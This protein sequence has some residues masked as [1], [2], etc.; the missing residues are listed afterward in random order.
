MA[1]ASACLPGDSSPARSDPDA[2]RRSRSGAVTLTRHDMQRETVCDEA[3]TVGWQ[4][5]RAL[6]AGAAMP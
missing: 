2:E 6:V 3:G 1:M 5:E 4:H